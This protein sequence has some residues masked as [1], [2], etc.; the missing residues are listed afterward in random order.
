MSLVLYGESRTGKTVWARSLGPHIYNLG[1]VAGPEC[2]KAPS[3]RYAV[4]DDIR[5]GIKFFHG[6]KEWLGGQEYACVK[7]LYKDAKLVKWGKPTIWISNTDPR[8]EMDPSDASWLNANA[9]FIEIN[10]PIFRASTE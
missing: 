2:L 4:F 1:L 7:Q 5:G 10:V 8:L 6:F 9:R 3:V